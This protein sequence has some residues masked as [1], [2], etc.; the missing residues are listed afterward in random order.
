MANPL[1]SD[2]F[3]NKWQKSINDLKAD[4]DKE[5]RSRR[6]VV[7]EG[8]STN[9]VGSALPTKPATVNSSKHD[10]MNV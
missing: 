2:D 5:Q 8:P 4:T 6:K 10:V 7:F 9:Q 3:A 1:F